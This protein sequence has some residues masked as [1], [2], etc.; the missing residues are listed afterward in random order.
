MNRKCLKKRGRAWWIGSLLLCFWIVGC[1]QED[2]EALR[3]DLDNQ[4][5]R[6]AALEA[7]LEGFNANWVALQSLLEAVK[8]SKYITSVTE[9]ASGYSLILS[10]GAVLRV[11]HGSKGNPGPAGDVFMP[12]VSVRDSSDGHSYWTVNGSLLRDAGGQ[13]VRMDGEKGEVGSPGEM[14]ASGITPQ[15]R[16]NINTNEWE[17]SLDRGQTWQGT[18]VKA[19]GEKG[20]PGEPGAPGPEG[21]EGPRGDM[22]FAENGVNIGEDY[23]EFT[24]ADALGTHFRVPLYH[25]LSLTF[26]RGKSV[27]MPVG[28]PKKIPFKIEGTG[29]IPSVSAIGNGGWEVLVEYPVGQADSGIIWVT[30]PEVAGKASSVVLLHDGLGGGWSYRLDL[31][32]LPTPKMIFVPGGSLRIIGSHGEGWSVTDYYIS[33]TTI[34]AGQYCDFLNSC[35]PVPTDED[36][37]A[38]VDTA[39]F[40]TYV[41]PGY[42]NFCEYAAGKWQPWEGEVHYASGNRKESLKNY[43]VSVGW[44]GAAAYCRWAGGKLQTQAEY[45]YAA[46]GSERNPN[47]TI[48]KYPGSNNPDEV[49][50]YRENSRSD[51]AY[52]VVDNGGPHPVAQKKPNFLGIYD[53][54][55]NKQE[56]YSD[57]V[58]YYPP[59]QTWTYPCRGQWGKVN[60]LGEGYGE[61]RV[62]KGT[63][64][65]STSSDMYISSSF[66]SYSQILS[67]GYLLVFNFGFRLVYRVE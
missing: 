3:R 24:L 10:D 43:P 22:I 8:N 46:R 58:G 4:A 51:G 28:V 12:T 48:E 57:S 49:G 1:E 54:F 53:M 20:D 5:L 66:P 59:G 39:W 41:E 61:N 16:I 15:I 47:A 62:V 65:L 21:P 17:I 42:S 2:I 64:W 6:L 52:V 55:G 19:T 25:R 13:P 40:E 30:S 38:M 50:W 23:V 44:F 7:Q 34:T 37:Y 11:F 67:G 29:G 18:G 63:E 45:E 60:P 31:L 27:R 32:A 26:P 56:W 35:R 36:I 14:G 33:E 9:N